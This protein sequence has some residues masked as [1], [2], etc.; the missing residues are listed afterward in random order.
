MR[1]QR[2]EYIPDKG[3]DKTPE[4]QLSEVEICPETIQS[5]DSKDDPGISEKEWKH[6]LRR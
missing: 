6:T 4:E 1:C 3:T 5:N 2:E